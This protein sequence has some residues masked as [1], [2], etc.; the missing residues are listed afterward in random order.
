MG[1]TTEAGAVANRLSRPN[2]TEDQCKPESEKTVAISEISAR[3]ED[4]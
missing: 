2:R 3:N 1:S 4:R